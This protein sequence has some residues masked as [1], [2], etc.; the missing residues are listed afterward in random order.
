MRRRVESLLRGRG[1]FDLQNHSSLQ[2]LLLRSRAPSARNLRSGSQNCTFRKAFKVR[3]EFLSSTK[4][5]LF[6]ACLSLRLFVFLF[7][8]LSL[9][10]RP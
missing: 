2:T 10:V 9:R 5:F 6:T 4:A 1:E 8:L 3:R 7:V